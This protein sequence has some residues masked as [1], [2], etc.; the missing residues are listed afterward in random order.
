MRNRP[1]R[2]LAYLLWATILVIAA[3]NPTTVTAITE[4]LTGIVLA[5]TNGITAAAVN[6]PG[7]TVLT[8][9]AAWIAW[10]AWN[11]RPKTRARAK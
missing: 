11:T 2:I 9:G 1:N 7:P 3:T 6:Q 8:I 4:A 5:I 10:N